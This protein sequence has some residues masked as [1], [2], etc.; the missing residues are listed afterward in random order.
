MVDINRKLYDENLKSLS[1]EEGE[2]EI[3][4]LTKENLE[5][6]G[7]LDQYGKPSDEFKKV[8][9]TLYRVSPLTFKDGVKFWDHLYRGTSLY[10]KFL[11]EE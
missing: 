1:A 6:I 8:L 3:I 2:I 10:N 5:L 4:E 7:Y 11:R 9:D